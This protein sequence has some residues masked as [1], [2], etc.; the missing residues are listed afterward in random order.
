MSSALWTH[1]EWIG[2]LLAVVAIAALAL[3]AAHWRARRNA[4]RL[5]PAGG[6]SLRRDVIS[7]IA[8]LAAVAAIACALL[9]P[10]IGERS[11]WVPSTGVDVVF[12]LDVSRSMEAADVP[13][14]RLDRALR[15]TEEILSRL[16]PQD[17]AAIAAFAGRGVL[18]TPLTPDH[19]ALAD[20]LPL[21]D[22]S[23]IEPASSQIASG[24]RAALTAFES[25]SERPR[26]VVVLS[27]GEDPDHGRD[28]AG[29]DAAHEQVRIVTVGFGREIGSHILV[30]GV[31][32]RDIDGRAV[33]SRRRLHRL[34][35]LAAATGGE[36]IAADEWGRFDFA[37][38]TAVIRRDTTAIPGERGERRIRTVRVAPFALLAFALLL[39]EALPPPGRLRWPLPA[40]VAVALSVLA[41]LGS[42]P[43]ARSDERS[44]SREGSEQ[45]DS[46]DARTLIAAGLGQLERGRT[47]AAA[48]SFFSAAVRAREPAVAAVARYDLGVAALTAGDLAGARDAFFAAL[49]DDP[50]DREAR[51]NLE[52][53]LAALEPQPAPPATAPPDPQID[54]GEADA[55]TARQRDRSEPT[56][57]AGAPHAEHPAPVTLTPEQRRRALERIVDDP[58][59]W[60]RAASD[61][62]R[63]ERQQR[64]GAAW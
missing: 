29:G 18:L 35:E 43:V 31:P 58:G 19:G 30:D 24:L 7:D 1:P 49:E 21:L 40:A 44:G 41:A 25:G 48:A 50:D 11:V 38:A 3:A 55:E 37:H 53:A 14:S 27:D 46:R 62:G 59:R 34:E 60:L 33:V 5:F 32:L 22:T 23:F 26:V 56:L 2:R 57:A 8:L 9:G 4:R 36:A 12:L 39:L 28:L 13:P 47:A 6:I 42:S 17:R 16:G 15:A 51:F 10:R 64:S 20:L 45:S 61:D 54:R 52:W 63:Q